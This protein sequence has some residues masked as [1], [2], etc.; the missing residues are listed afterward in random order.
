[1]TT[2]RV[3][4]TRAARIVAEATEGQPAP[5]AYFASETALTAFN[6]MMRDMRGQEIGQKLARQWSASAGDTAIAGGL[7]KVNVYT[8][9]EPRNGDRIGV[10]GARSVTATADTIETAASVTTAA[11]T[12][13]FYREDMADWL[14]EEDLGLDDESLLSSECDEALAGMLAA[15]A[16]LEQT[17]AVAQGLSNFALQGRGRIRRLYKPVEVIAAESAVLR[18]MAQRRC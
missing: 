17:G 13:W 18:S 12:S 8:P 15:R 1:M 3:I 5:T 16:Q 14:K 10:I 6:D 2:V 4:M 11:S 9:D 7:Y